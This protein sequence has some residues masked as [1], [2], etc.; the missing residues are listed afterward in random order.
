MNGSEAYATYVRPKLANL[1]R[2]I[3]LDV[4]YETASGCYLWPQ[5][6]REPVLDLVGGYG[7]LLFGHNHPEIV[8]TVVEFLRAGRPVLAQG[9]LKD[10]T[11]RLAERL[12]MNGT[13][14][15]LFANSGAEA[16]EIALKH[17]LLERRGPIVALKNG[18]HGKT[19]GA[20][21]LTEKYCDGYELG[22][23]VLRVPANDTGALRKVFTESRPAA[24]FLEL[25]QGEGGVVP[26]TQEF[27]ALAREL[28]TDATLVVD[29][30]QTGLGRTG[31]FLACE[32]YGVAPDI[33]LLSKALGGGIA[34]IS[35]TLIRKEKYRPELGLMHTSTF[36]DDELSSAVA[37]K[38][39]DLITDKALRACE[40]TGRWLRD[41]L[42]GCK[43]DYPEVIRDVRGM[44]LMLGIE[45]HPPQAGAVLKMMGE[46]LGLVIAG[47]LLNRHRIRVAP[48]LS[49]PMT[50]RV[51]PPLV[52][53]RAELERFVSAVRDVCEKIR[54]GDSLGLTEYFLPAKPSSDP[55]VRSGFATW[56]E[57]TPTDLPRVGWLFHL[58]DADDLSSMDPAFGSLGPCEREEYLRHVERRIRPVVMNSIDVT[59][60]T[61]KRVRFHAVLLPLTSARVKELMAAGDPWLQELVERGIDAAEALGCGVVS[62]G[63]YTSIVMNNGLAVRPRK[64]G[65]TT[66]N[67]YTVALAIEALERAVPDLRRRTVAVVGATGNI[68]S[69]TSELLA[70]R[71]REILLIGRN[72]PGAIARMGRLN[73]PNARISTDVG[74]CRRAEVVVVAVN[75]P[76]PVVRGEHLAPGAL[77]CDLSVPAGVDAPQHRVIRGGIARMPNGE[78]HRIPGFPI[79]GGLAYACMAEGILLAFEGIHSRHFTGTLTADHVRTIAGLARRHGFSLAEYKIKSVVGAMHA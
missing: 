29:E 44:G 25:I 27:V 46:D 24:L 70:E 49:R 17:V 57:I 71:C 59:S 20:L 38:V 45:F 15:V 41:R 7:A 64:I 9:S 55:D 67:A 63:Q 5:G 19:L 13:Y 30:I 16:V 51:Q 75:S 4:T 28:C 52:T 73:L 58:I 35:A 11:G 31:R 12:S 78:H 48:T 79:D 61:G 6:A 72:T 1:L 42:T 10:L 69:I 43:H 36:A 3:H 76:V 23:P 33:V 37:L 8:Q 40:E 74:D 62:L 18:F 50:L 26:L 14:R 21:Q 32:H 77:V 60:R 54:A 39:L 53:P 47:Y 34:K 56:C 66:G 65:V 2:L 68:G 22:L